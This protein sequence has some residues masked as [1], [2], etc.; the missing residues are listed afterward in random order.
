[1]KTVKLMD[2]PNSNEL[3]QELTIVNTKWDYINNSLKNLTIRIKKKPEYE[4]KEV[5]KEEAP[6]IINK[7]YKR[8]RK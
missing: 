3:I 7:L 2:Q 5:I 6:N 1:M 8:Q 4:E